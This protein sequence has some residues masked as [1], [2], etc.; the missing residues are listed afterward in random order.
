MNLTDLRN[1]TIPFS[2]P[3]V[4]FAKLS[5]G[6]FL[7]RLIRAKTQR[8]IIY[9]ALLVNTLFSIAYFFLVLFQ[10]FPVSIYVSGIPERNIWEN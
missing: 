5:I 1:L 7:L 8:Y 9:F 6:F 3:V 10:C 2:P 4:M